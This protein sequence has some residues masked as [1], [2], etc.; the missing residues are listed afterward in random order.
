MITA[1]IKFHPGLAIAIQ[2][3]TLSSSLT[4]MRMATVISSPRIIKLITEIGIS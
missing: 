4:S 1:H 3:T 2:L